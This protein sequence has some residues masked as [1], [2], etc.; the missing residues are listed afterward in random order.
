MRK[1]TVFVSV[2]LFCCAAVP[3]FC[4]QEES[5]RSVLSRF[6]RV[7][8]SDEL[9]RQGTEQII[10]MFREN[11]PDIPDTFWETEREKVGDLFFEGLVDMLESIYQKYFTIS[12]IYEVIAFYESPVGRKFAAA[13]PAITW[14]GA[15]LGGQLGMQVVQ[16]IYEDLESA[17]YSQDLNPHSL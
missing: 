7:S 12:D 9:A 11:M 16:E 14:E 1:L 10:A 13:S 8:N 15:R 4:E 5:Y 3:L 17:G 2:V 6:L